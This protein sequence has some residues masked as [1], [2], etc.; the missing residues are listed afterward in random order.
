VSDTYF[1][2]EAG[3][4]SIMMYINKHE[5]GK[6][7]G[8]LVINNDISNQFITLHYNKPISVHHTMNDSHSIEA[9]VEFTDDNVW[10]ENIIFEISPSKGRLRIHDGKKIYAL[11]WKDHEISSALSIADVEEQMQN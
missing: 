5:K 2:E 8:Y 10:P 1:A 7:D 11:L 3:I 4:S 6:R 9:K